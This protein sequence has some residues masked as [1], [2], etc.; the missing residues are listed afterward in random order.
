VA[1][2]IA[3]VTGAIGDSTAMAPIPPTSIADWARFPSAAGLFVVQDDNANIKPVM[4]M[5]ET[6]ILSNVKDEPRR[7]RARLVQDSGV[8]YEVS[9]GFGCG[10]TRRD[11]S[12]RW[13]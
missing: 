2:A 5:S 11:R 6:F 13:L 9:F 3:D 7:E 8:K 4:A 12:R 1:W 10:S